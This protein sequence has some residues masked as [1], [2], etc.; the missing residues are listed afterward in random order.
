MSRES[1]VAILTHLAEP[2][3]GTFRSPAAV[4][5]GVSRKQLGTL[6]QQGFIERVLP[7]TYRVTASTPSHDQTLCAALQWAG[8]QAVGDRS[9]STF[10]TTTTAAR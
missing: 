10:G 1:P 7:D 9:T 4:A 5:N 8:A 2:S 3:F 6:Q